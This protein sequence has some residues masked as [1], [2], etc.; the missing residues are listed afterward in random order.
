MTHPASARI[1][2]RVRVCAEQTGRGGS[3]ERVELIVRAAFRLD[4]S[5]S[6]K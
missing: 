5:V 6:V 1:N 3:V 2:E 4:L